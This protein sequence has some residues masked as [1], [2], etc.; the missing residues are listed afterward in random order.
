[1][2][3]S[4]GVGVRMRTHLI[5]AGCAAVV[6]GLPPA[7][8]Q[9]G[10]PNHHARLATA[11]AV[12]GQVPQGGIA[13]TEDRLL[14]DDLLRQARK[15]MDQGNWDLALTKI[16]QAKRLGVVYAPNTLGDTPDGLLSELMQKKSAGEAAPTARPT[17][18]R[19]LPSSSQASNSSDPSNLSDQWLIDARLA[20]SVGDIKRTRQLLNQVQALGLNYSVTEDSPAKVQAAIQSY[21]ELMAEKSRGGAETESFRRR[22]AAVLMEQ[23]EALLKWNRLQ[24]A[25]RLANDAAR[26]NV[27]YNPFEMTPL[28]LLDRIGV[29]QQ[30]Q[31]GTGPR[32][33]DPRRSHLQ[34]EGMLG[35]NNQGT[36]TPGVG[37]RGSYQSGSFR[38]GTNGTNLQEAEKLLEASRQAL[39][40]G[41]LNRAEEMANQVQQMQVTLPPGS[42]QPEMI[43]FEVA[44]K[45]KEMASTPTQS[46]LPPSQP[47]A[48][49][50][51]QPSQNMPAAWDGNDGSF[52]SQA[53]YTTEGGPS[54]DG[55]Q[56]NFEPSVQNAGGP[57]ASG[58]A[59]FEAGEQALRQGNV[60]KALGLYQ[61]AYAYKDNLDPVTV[62]RLQ[63]KLQ[64]LRMQ[65]PAE[66]QMTGPV[67]PTAAIGGSELLEKEAAVKDVVTRQ[68]LAEVTKK[69]YEA[70]ELREDDP[71]QA[72]RILRETQL[73]ID[74]SSTDAATKATLQRRL[75]ASIAEMEKHISENR[76][77]I[78][79]DERNQDVRQQIERERLYRMEVDES[80]AQMVEEFNRLMDEER[81]REAELIAKRAAVLAPEAP[82]V[83]T[84][85]FKA[86]FVNRYHRNQ[87]IEAAKENNFVA[88]MQSVDASGVPIDDNQ[89]YQFPH[90]TQW[91]QLTA[92]R[93]AL[94]RRQSR[95]NERELEIQQR[96]QTPVSV[97]FQ[98]KALSEV[99]EY[100]GTLAEIN[101]V[102]D[103]KGLAAEGVSTN[104]PVTLELSQPIMLKSAL[105]LILD[106]KNLSYVIK[107]EVLKI[108]SAQLKDTEVYPEVYQ[109]A[110]LVIPIPNFVP[111]GN[112]GLAQAL[113]DALG[114]TQGSSIGGGGSRPPVTVLAGQNGGTQSAALS[115][116]LLGQGGSGFGAGEGGSSVPGL[117][118]DG[119]G[120]GV[121]PDFDSLIDLITSTV[122]PQTWDEVGGPGSVQPF[123]TNL[124]LVVSQTQDVHE[125]IADLL[126][127]LRRLQDLQVTIEVRFITLNDNFFERIGLDFD[128][129]IDDD[130]D[131]PYQT[132]GQANPSFNPVFSTDGVGVVPGRDFQDRDHGDTA[133]VGVQ[134]PGV[135]SAD[136]D[137]PFTQGSF[138]L[139]SPSFGDPQAGA[140]ATLGFAILSDIEAFFFLEASQGDVRSNV[141]QA[142]KVTLFNG[143]LAFVADTSQSPFVISVIP[144]VGDFAAG[145]QPVIAVLSEGTFLTVQAVV[146]SDRRF[147]RLTLVPFFSKIDDVDEFT[148]TGSESTSTTTT[149]G[150]AE[151]G[152][153]GTEQQVSSRSGTTVQLPTFSF[154]TVTT[155]V[156]VPD[157]G[158]VLLGGIKR[159][160]E[161]RNEYGVPILNKLPYVNRL[162]SNVGIGRETQSLMMM[163]TPRIIIQEEEERLLLGGAGP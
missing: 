155:T 8:V 64:L 68:L 94:E 86:R 115:P 12:V 62:Q 145:F 39:A 53:E 110:D 150:D 84:M 146:S 162:F 153:N 121:E 5:I 27:R 10:L 116:H 36:T 87:S 137:I 15:A 112:M 120:G 85:T 91:E 109:V 3:V 149:D 106:P 40:A 132:F 14:S 23:S 133:T 138:P 45:R 89:P 151:D 140:G 74:N 48:T 60:A 130:I 96:L 6:F 142:P 129:D 61:Q 143:Q 123:E 46:S 38:T 98:E 16:S 83:Q 58:M 20:L 156:S 88:A 152:D 100:L 22:Y 7:W 159:L 55:Q 82:V 139:A 102:L 34:S 127:Q 47:V 17:G 30:T 35:Q 72:L 134:A 76:V 71:Q 90:I 103:P 101:I 49:K 4:K 50:P 2:Q 125:Q 28:K 26:L 44:K 93:Q 97:R 158:T 128:F 52:N 43:L 81:Y 9:A 75:D 104:E 113:Q 25:E 69:R 19:P 29:R 92:S 131:Q 141:L 37:P 32:T 161:G 56:V 99:I 41:D 148:F 77:M 70:R 1:M 126:N 18:M 66:K 33:W 118:P 107:D 163:V 160:N 42:D 111:S 67:Q 11:L 57:G 54:Y 114:A 79:L 65:A 51:A 136:L 147:V 80:L 73:L 119:F 59:L 24:E 144:V 31:P 108:T 105:S 135:F 154:V 21:E 124:S 117:G 95:F 63:D 78:E 122:A 13:A 157:G